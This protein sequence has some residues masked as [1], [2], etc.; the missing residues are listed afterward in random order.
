MNASGELTLN[1]TSNARRFNLKKIIQDYVPRNYQAGIKVTGIDGNAFGL[2]FPQHFDRVLLDAPCSSEVHVLTKTSALDAWNQARV[3]QLAHRQ[4]SL[5]CSGL[6]CLK[7]GGLLL[8]STC[9]I[10]PAENDRVLRKLVSKNR[11]PCEIIAPQ[12]SFGS[13]TEFGR[14]VLPHI[15]GAGPM[16]FALVRRL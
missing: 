7:P 1:D 6:N 9:S 4:Y 3:K 13:Q 2:R 14:I 16:F 12:I 11:H 10:A 15:D 5:L 8:Y